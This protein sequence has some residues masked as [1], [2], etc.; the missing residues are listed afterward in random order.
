MFQIFQIDDVFEPKSVEGTLLKTRSHD[1]VYGAYTYEF[2]LKRGKLTFSVLNRKLHEVTYD[3]PRLFPWSK[4]KRNRQLLKAYEQG[5]DWQPVFKNKS[6]Y[7]FQSS[8]YKYFA[9]LSKVND[10][11]T[12]GTMMFYEERYR[13]VT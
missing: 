5:G 10:T 13:L 6:G 3:C 2:Q 11:A 1:T 7:L 4:N 8:D 12:F 9:A